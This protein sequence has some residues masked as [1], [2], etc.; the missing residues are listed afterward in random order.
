MATFTDNWWASKR[1]GTGNMHKCD[2]CRKATPLECA[3]IGQDDRTGIV[4]VYHGES[5]TVSQ[6][7]RY[8]QGALPAIGLGVAR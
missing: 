3:W 4:T 8:A 7:L 2:D 1:K 5:E 6:C